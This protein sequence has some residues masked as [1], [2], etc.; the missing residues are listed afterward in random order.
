MEQDKFACFLFLFHTATPSLSRIMSRCIVLYC[1]VLQDESCKS[2]VGFFNQQRGDSPCTGSPVNI[3]IQR[4][5]HFFNVI[6]ANDTKESM[7]GHQNVSSP[8]AGI[9]PDNLAPEA[10]MCANH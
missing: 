8:A 3:P 4:T 1:T 5:A 7:F 6:P 2:T 9:K 10:S